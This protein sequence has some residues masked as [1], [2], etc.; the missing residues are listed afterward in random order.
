MASLH[1]ALSSHSFLLQREFA[2]WSLGISLALLVC[3]TDHRPLLRP[4]YRHVGKT[5][6]D[7]GG[8]Y[9]ASALLIV[10]GLL[11]FIPVA[12]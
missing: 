8:Y 1:S 12:L 11:G 3:R 6:S 2:C 4:R 5:N 9:N 10:A 7:F